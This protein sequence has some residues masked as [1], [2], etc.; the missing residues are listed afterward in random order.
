MLEE[1]HVTAR[2]Q[3]SALST[4]GHV[5]LLM[6]YS[7]RASWRLKTKP[8]ILLNAWFHV[9]LLAHL[10]H[11]SRSVHRHDSYVSCQ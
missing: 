5:S 2:L 9:D 11:W 7:V 4:V 8:C 6:F 10:C 1:T 3:T